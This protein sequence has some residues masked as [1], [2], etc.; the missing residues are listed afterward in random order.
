LMIALG[1]SGKQGVA[2]VLGVAAVVCVS[3]AVAGDMFQDLK[4]GYI[5]GGTP[6]RLQLGN[7]LSAAV[8]SLIMFL[9][10]VI[11]HQ[12][13]INAGRMAL[14][15]YEGGFGSVNLPAV[16]AGLMTFL[17]QGIMG[18]HMAWPLLIVGMVMGFG[19]IMMQVRSPI[20]VSIGM[21]L[22]L[23]TT[24]AIFIGG[25]IKGLIEM[26]NTRKKFNDA[27]KA[28]VENIGILIAAG[29][30]AGESLFALVLAGFAFANVSIFTFFQNPSFLVS[31]CVF[32]FI[33]WY[34]I[35]VPIRHA[36][37]PDQPAPP[38]ALM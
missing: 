1:L 32:A 28:R 29:L 25:L 36:G 12:G 20:L 19:F 7:L 4:A 22:S 34:L 16:Q 2:A 35:A 13:D 27:Q 26:V 18:G 23:E 38:Q 15:P 33:A 24:F 31:L 37:S 14:H 10:L 3:S 30:I 21:Y 9:P 8:S 11:L 6:W 17:A 5:L